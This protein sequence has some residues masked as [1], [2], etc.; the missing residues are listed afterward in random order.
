MTYLLDANVFVT[1][2][3]AHYGLDFVPG[4]WE[5]IAANHSSGK[6]RS[7]DKVGHE[8]LRGHDELAEWAKARPSGFFATCSPAKIT[9]GLID[10]AKWASSPAK[11]F[12]P[13]AISEFLQSADYYLVAHAKAEGYVV[14]THETSEPNSKKRVKIPDACHHL[15]VQYIN[16]FN[17]LRTEQARFR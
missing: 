8:L 10:L 17:M 2:K 6:L 13:S 5:W 7:I 11:S 3:N 12:K 16:P 1:A 4:F 9:P 14:V 15:G